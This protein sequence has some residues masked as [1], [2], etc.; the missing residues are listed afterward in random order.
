MNAFVLSAVVIVTAVSVIMVMLAVMAASDIRIVYK[1]IS[2]IRLYRA[3][4]RARY[5]SEKLYT[6]IQKSHLRTTANS[7]AYEYINAHSLQKACKSAVPLS[8]SVNHP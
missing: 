7:A 4:T 1:I 2:E 3:V 8:E 5:S 6:C